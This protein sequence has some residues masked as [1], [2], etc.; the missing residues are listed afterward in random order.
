MFSLKAIVIIFIFFLFT[1]CQFSPGT[2][3]EENSSNKVAKANI[4]LGLELIRQGYFNE[5]KKKLQLAKEMNSEDPIVYSALGYLNETIGERG[6]AKKNYELALLLEPKNGAAHNN[7]GV[8]LFHLGEYNAAIIE[9]LLAVK[10]NDYLE[11]AATYENLGFCACK[12][13]HKE[14]ATYYFQKALTREPRSATA[15]YYL[16]KLVNGR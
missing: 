10:D 6:E 9:F 5:A 3:T 2:L 4:K 8:F 14:L 1:G 7:Y 11:T 12:I 15:K 16:N 13:G